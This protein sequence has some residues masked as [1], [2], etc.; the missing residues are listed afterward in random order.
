ML[1]RS[2]SEWNGWSAIELA[3]KAPLVSF[4]DHVQVRKVQKVL[5]NGRINN[6]STNWVVL[7]LCRFPL[8]GA[9]VFFPILYSLGYVHFHYNNAF[10][11]HNRNKSHYKQFDCNFLYNW[12]HFYRSPRSVIREGFA[13]IKFRK[14]VLSEIF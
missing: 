11:T 9:F 10:Q 5:W 3:N 4:F 1:R 2:C 14:V 7:R 12:L 6:E 13:E 8:L